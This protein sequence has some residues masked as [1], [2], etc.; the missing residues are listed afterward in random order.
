M[1]ATSIEAVLLHDVV[2]DSPDYTLNDIERLFGNAVARIVD[3]LTKI[4]LY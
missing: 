2:E 4:S 1:D 3:G